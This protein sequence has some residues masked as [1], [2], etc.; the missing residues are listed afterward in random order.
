M[1]E[2]KFSGKGGVYAKARPCYPNELFEYLTE[3]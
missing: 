3:H 2:Q 1:N